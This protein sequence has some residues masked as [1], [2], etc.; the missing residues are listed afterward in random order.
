MPPMLEL[1]RAHLA[2]TLATRLSEKAGTWTPDG[3]TVRSHGSPTVTIADLHRVAPNHIDIGVAIDPEDPEAPVIWDCAAGIGETA[4]AVAEVAAHLWVE[5]TGSTVLE[6]LTH[7][8]ELAAHTPGDDPYGLPGFHVIEGPMVVYGHDTG[9]L[10]EWVQD[11]PLLPALRSTL[12][13]HLDSAV[14]GVKVLFGGSEENVEV[15]V[16]TEVR[17]D[18]TAAVRAL[19]YPRTGFAR[20][21]LIAFPEEE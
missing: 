5:T 19:D 14:N 6:L 1:D 10:R 16:N 2:R 3:D 17:E 20:V 21:F 18:V 11:N 13:R 15:R 8:G 9:P 7:R 12:P 4:E